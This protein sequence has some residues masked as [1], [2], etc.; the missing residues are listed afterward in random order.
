MFVAAKIIVDYLTQSSE[1]IEISQQRASALLHNFLH[2]DFT[3]L[4]EK[5]EVFREM[6]HKITASTLPV[7]VLFPYFK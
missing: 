6:A 5:R 1:D 7:S 3:E 2:R 4:Q